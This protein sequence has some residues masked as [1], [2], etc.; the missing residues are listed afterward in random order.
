[1]N[2]VISEPTVDNHV[3]SLE[4]VTGPSNLSSPTNFQTKGL[5]LTPERPDIPGIT[6]TTSITNPGPNLGLNSE[7]ILNKMLN[8]ERGDSSP[9]DNLFVDDTFPVMTAIAPERL[10]K[11]RIL[12]FPKPIEIVAGQRRQ[13]PRAAK[14]ARAQ[15]SEILENDRLKSLLDKPIPKK[16]N[17]G[18]TVGVSYEQYDSLREEVQ[19]TRVDVI[20]GFETSL[21]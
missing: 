13:P 6:E 18:N 7:E 14:T 19:H 10:S 3:T 9:F 12:I 16:A 15:V 4:P 1:L 17:K 11:S 2:H 20:R 8:S 21:K 5:E